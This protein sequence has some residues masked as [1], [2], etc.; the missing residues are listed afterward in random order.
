MNR[1]SSVL[2]AAGHFLVDLTCA[3][4]MLALDVGPWLFFIYNLCAFALQMPLGLLADMFGRNRRFALLG[5]GLVLLALLPVETSHFRVILVGLGNAC[6]HVGGGR[7]ALVSHRGLTGLGLFVA[8]G[9]VGIFFGTVFAGNAIVT[10]GAAILLMLLFGLI[11][12]VCTSEAILVPRGTPRKGIAGV[13]LLVVILRSLVGLCM[14]SPWKLGVYVILG[15]LAGAAGKALGGIFADRFGGKL[16]GVISL[17]LS[18]VL[19][20][21]PDIGIAGVLGCLLFNMTM[22]I[23]LGKAAAALPGYEGLSFGLLTFGLF[24]GYVPS[25]MGVSLSPWLGALLS[26]ASAGLLLLDREEAH[27]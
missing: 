8:P 23:T 7:E 18:A 13:M 2:Y 22:P 14:E 9:A 4:T 27:A 20:C 1:L 5:I 10:A 26:L 24:L 3:L 15:A 6:Y 17:A 11:F 25:F 12:A 16:V 19:F 21:L